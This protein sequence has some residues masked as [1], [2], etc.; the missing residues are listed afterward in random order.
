MMLMG[1][2]RVMAAQSHPSNHPHSPR[3][4]R[5]DLT[6]TQGYA[7]RSQHGSQYMDERV[8]SS[9]SPSIL[10]STFGTAWGIKPCLVSAW[11]SRGS[12]RHPAAQSAYWTVQ[13]AYTQP[14]CQLAARV[15]RPSL[16]GV[17]RHCAIGIA[18]GWAQR[19]RASGHHEAGV[20]LHR[21]RRLSQRPKPLQQI[22]R[23]MNFGGC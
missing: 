22:C 21:P 9:T 17:G 14:S 20:T 4:A 23:A 7:L 8:V 1:C 13:E 10:L 12:W 19:H 18:G 5:S 3:S 2:W 15:R 6:R 11:H 16:T